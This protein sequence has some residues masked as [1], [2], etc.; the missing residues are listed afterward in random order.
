MS[1]RHAPPDGC[2]N[3]EACAALEPPRGWHLDRSVSIGH[4]LTTLATA[5]ALIAWAMR[6]ENR[7]ATLETASRTAQS[8]LE[9]EESERK[10]LKTEIRQELREIRALLESK[11]R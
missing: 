10:E 5:A 6:Q 8:A 2:P 11:R 3:G 4:I 9:R 7:M 1:P